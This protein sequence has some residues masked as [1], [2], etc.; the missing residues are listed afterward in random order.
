[1]YYTDHLPITK[2]DDLLILQ[3][4]LVTEIKSRGKSCFITCLCR[5]PS[6]THDQIEDFYKILDLFL[7]NINNLNSYC[8][9]VSVNFNP[10]KG[11]I[12]EG[13]SFCGGSS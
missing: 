5:Q 4:C 1:M 2:R 13:S 7:F 8:S 9:A 3:E 12:L 11:E 10:N 6:Q